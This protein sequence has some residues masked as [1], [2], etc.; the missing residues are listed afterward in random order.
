M[1]KL[2]IYQK[3]VEISNR[4]RI[5]K[6]GA[7]TFANYNYFTPDGI[8]NALN[9]LMKEYGLICMFSLPYDN[10]MYR[11]TL[12]IKDIESSG[13]VETTFG[14]EVIYKFDMPRTEVRGASAGQN[15]GATMT[16]CKRYMLMNAFNIADNASDFDSDTMAKK[17]AKS[18]KIE[19]ETEVISKVSLA[20]TI[21]QIRATT[22]TK[23]LSF[24]KDKTE[25]ARIWNDTQKKVILDAIEE[26]L[27]GTN[28]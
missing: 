14:P 20:D 16:Y 8:A 25:K 4:I 10:E 18:E 21:K 9:P 12:T 5:S 2:N 22:D 6:D 26:Q 24:W 3:I 17:I 13:A 11:G 23:R 28:N 7:N 1:D 15:A 27:N 19:D